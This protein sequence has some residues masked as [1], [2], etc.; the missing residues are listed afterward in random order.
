MNMT[1]IARVATS[2]ALTVVV[3]VLKMG[4]LRSSHHILV[5]IMKGCVLMLLRTISVQEKS[6]NFSVCGG[7]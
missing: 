4:L 3:C 6:G 2:E 7:E 5:F 1:G